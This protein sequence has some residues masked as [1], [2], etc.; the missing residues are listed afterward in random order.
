MDRDTIGLVLA[1]TLAGLAVLLAVVAL[2]RQPFL[3]LVALPFA[4]GAYLV[5]RGATGQFSWG[6]TGGRFEEY[7]SGE[8]GRGP[9]REASGPYRQANGDGGPFQQAGGGPFG[10]G[11]N[12]GRTRSAAGR[13]SRQQWQAREARQ[14]GRREAQAAM[15]R[16]Q[17]YQTLGLSP[18]ADADA[19]KSAYRRKVKTTHP[20]ADGGNRETFQRV[21]A[22]YELLKE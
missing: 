15:E 22:A 5:W 12:R 8:E 1:S 19:V 17:A 11:R 4:A 21:N 6:L 13:A 16:R 18:D 14:R 2:A 9:Y 7:L 3:L 20:D 10:S